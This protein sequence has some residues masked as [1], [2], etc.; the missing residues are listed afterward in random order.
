[1]DE[2]DIPAWIAL[3]LSLISLGTQYHTYREHQ[4]SEAL[5]EKMA[6][7]A[8]ME[9]LVM[10]IRTTAIA[11]W[12]HS[13]AAAAKDGLMLIHHLKDLSGE[14]T[15]NQTLLWPNARADV[16][17]IKIQV[18]GSDF[19]R[20]DRLGRP[21]N[22]P[23]ITAFSESCSRFHENLRSAAHAAKT[24]KFDEQLAHA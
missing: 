9:A 3:A 7:L 18:T 20:I 12:L 4:K 1:M 15:R 10:Q 6:R 13:E 17:N 5:N 2:G 21:A 24:A 14:V 16:M 19:Q 23:L 8:H 22:D 11:Y